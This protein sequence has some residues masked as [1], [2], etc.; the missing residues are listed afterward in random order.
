M[1]HSSFRSHLISKL[2]GVVCTLFAVQPWLDCLSFWSNSSWTLALRLTL[3][4][5]TTGTG[6][7]LSSRKRAYYRL[8]GI[9]LFLG[10][11]HLWAVCM[12]GAQDLFTDTANFV[13][14]L[15][16]PCTA[17]ALITCLEAQPRCYGA[18]KSGMAISLGSILFITLLSNLTGTE[19]H[20]YEDGSGILGWFSNTNSQSA[21]L[22]MTVPVAVLWASQQK[23]WKH[24]L[25][26]FLCLGGLSALYLL[27]TRLACFALLA[28]GVGL[29]F[30]LLRERRREGA[31]LIAACLLFTALLPWSP[32]VEHQKQYY[33][34]QYDR[35]AQINSSLSAYDLPSLEEPGLTEAELAARQALWVEALTPIYTFYVPDFVELFG[36]EETIAIC[37]YSADIGVMTELRPKKLKFAQLLMDGSPASAKVFGLELSRFTVGENNYDVENDFHG[38]YYLYG[39]AGLAAMLLFLGYFLARLMRSLRNQGWTFLTADT[40]AWSIALGCCLLHCYFTA[41]VLRR[42][43]AAFYLAAC[44]AAVYQLTNK[45][46][47]SVQ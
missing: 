1:T 13:R 10:L 42:P 18:L 44:L 32:M 24:P 15:Q 34:V 40:V 12:C 46:P 33:A 26:W 20:T 14:V 29:S 9:C 21:I 38:I 28:T 11:G 43:N 17:L 23:G 39:A 41:G 6:F 8:A 35:Q 5:L 31:V 4:A 47:P 45:C 7:F 2:P 22:S 37:D 19:P 3:L 25:F 27:G 16:L 30:F 36:A